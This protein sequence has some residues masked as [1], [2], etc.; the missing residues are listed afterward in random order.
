MHCLNLLSAFA[1]FLKF[2]KRIPEKKRE[3]WTAFNAIDVLFIK[4]IVGDL[5]NKLFEGT[6]R[7]ISIFTN[8]CA[9]T[10]LYLFMLRGCW[11][12]ANP[13][14]AGE[15]L[16]VD[17]SWLLIQRIAASAHVCMPFSSAKNWAIAMSK[18]QGAQH[19]WKAN[20]ILTLIRIAIRVWM[21]RFRFES[22]SESPERES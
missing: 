4:L 19:S 18:W 16:L 20:W 9:K 22:E 21:L 5:I 8:I 10:F 15:L 12:L 6:W 1:F 3:K 7:Y 13:Q 11:L 17:C 2:Q 14:Q